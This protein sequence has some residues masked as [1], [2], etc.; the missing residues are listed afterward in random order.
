M[1]LHGLHQRIDRLLAEVEPPTQW[2]CPSAVELAEMAGLFLDD[3]QK[4]LVSST[5]C[6][7][8]H[9][10]NHKGIRRGKPLS[11]GRDEQDP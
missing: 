2:E 6:A 5:H 1:Q 11:A 8:R 7:P 9:R 10:R 3:W 4:Q